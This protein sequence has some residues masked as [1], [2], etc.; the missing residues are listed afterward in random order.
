MHVMGESAMSRN[1]VRHP[2]GTQHAVFDPGRV[3][4][5]SDIQQFL[6]DYDR[7]RKEATATAQRSAARMYGLWRG[8]WAAG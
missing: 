6:L 2:D 3:A 5:M 1:R 4:S 8:R 7:N